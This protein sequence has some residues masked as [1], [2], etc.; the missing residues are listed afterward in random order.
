MR[1]GSKTTRN[2]SRDWFMAVKHR[3]IKKLTKND[4]LTDIFSSFP[5][6]WATGI[7]CPTLTA[8]EMC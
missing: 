8:K 2:Q 5:S 4:K 7:P 6:T 1:K 3:N